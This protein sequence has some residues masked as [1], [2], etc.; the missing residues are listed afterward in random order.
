MSKQESFYNARAQIVRDI[1]IRYY[2]D[3]DPKLGSFNVTAIKDLCFNAVNLF[4]HIMEEMDKKS[5]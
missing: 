1:V 2:Q 5:S 3:R 4:E